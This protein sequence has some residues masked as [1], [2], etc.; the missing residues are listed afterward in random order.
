MDDIIILIVS[1]WP[2]HKTCNI[3][4]LALRGFIGGEMVVEM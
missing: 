2:D 4:G 1:E 3:Q